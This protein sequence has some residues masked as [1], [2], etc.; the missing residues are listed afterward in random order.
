MNVHRNTYLGQAM[1]FSSNSYGKK[2]CGEKISCGHVLRLE[3]A[4]QTAHP[5]HDCWAAGITLLNLYAAIEGERKPTT[6]ESLLENFD[7]PIWGDTP[8]EIKTIIQRFLHPNIKI[9]LSFLTDDALK[10]MRILEEDIVVMPKPRSC[11]TL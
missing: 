7:D 5:V 4:L 10:M 8:T 3:H 11:L 6:V 2:L 1:K 9:R